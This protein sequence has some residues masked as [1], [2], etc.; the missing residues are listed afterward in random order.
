MNTT[1]F[2]Y[3]SNFI[4]ESAGVVLT[5]E[6]AYLIDSRLKPLVKDFGLSSLGDLVS[7][8]KAGVPAVQRAVMDALTTNETSFFR[9][10]KPFELFRHVVLPYLLQTRAAQRRFRIWSAACS[11]GQE[12]YS[13]A[14]ILTEEQTKLRDW[15][16]EIVATDVSSEALAKAKAGIYSQFEVQRGLPATMLVR[17]FTKDGDGWRIK[18]PLRSRI[19]FCPFN[20]LNDPTPLGR[21]DVIFCRNVL[22]YFD[23][24]TKA[25]VLARLAQQLAADGFLFL[26]G[27]E[28][29]IGISD[30]F[31]PE[32]GQRGL[33]RRA[34]TGNAT[35]MAAR[36]SAR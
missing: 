22:I 10:L 24:P 3:L 7:R 12:P 21:F 14:M 31:A 18:D 8:L 29:V 4:H 26:G 35:D 5:K 27:A 36:A 9:D 2:A 25:N 30:R 28:T 32:P 16:W 13:L 23:P 6:K 34:A 11:T 19:D 33:Y 20:L 15:S 17:Y 1:D